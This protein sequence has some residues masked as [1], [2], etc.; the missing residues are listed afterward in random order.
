MHQTPQPYWHDYKWSTNVSY[1]K[2]GIPSAAEVI[3]ITKHLDGDRLTYKFPKG[4]WKVVRMYMAPTNICNAPALDGDGRGLE[5]DRWNQEA[6][7]HHYDSYIGDIMRHVPA[8]DR[9]TWKVIVCDSYEKATQ[10]Y[11]DDFVEYFTK[12]FGYDPTPYLLTFS[13]QVV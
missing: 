13:G 6:L 12:H 9:K 2:K 11:G 8:E 1:D 3:D 4:D 10:N 5:V 7:Q